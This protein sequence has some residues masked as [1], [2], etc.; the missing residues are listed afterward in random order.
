[1]A[2]KW[3]GAQEEARLA[4]GQKQA[5]GTNHQLTHPQ[6]CRLLRRAMAHAG[7]LALMQAQDAAGAIATIVDEIE[8]GEHD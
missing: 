3:R 1:M 5:L 2:T 7:R 6:L 8:R 4:L